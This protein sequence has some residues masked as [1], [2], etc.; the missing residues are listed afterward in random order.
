MLLTPS[1]TL[2][3]PTPDS[4][5]TG[6]FL[7]SEPKRH[8]NPH[9]ARTYHEFNPVTRTYEAFDMNNEENSF[10]DRCPLD[11]RLS[12]WSM[13]RSYMKKEEWEQS[14]KPI[15][16]CHLNNNECSTNFAEGKNKTIKQNSQLLLYLGEISGVFLGSGPEKTEFLLKEYKNRN[17]F[18][19]F[20]V[21]FSE[22]LNCLYVRENN[23]LKEKKFFVQNILEVELLDLEP[24]LITLHVLNEAQNESIENLHFHLLAINENQDFVIFI[25]EKIKTLGKS[26]LIQNKSGKIRTPQQEMREFN[27]KANSTQKEKFSGSEG[28]VP[29]SPPS[30]GVERE[31]EQK[32]VEFTRFSTKIEKDDEKITEE[33]II[34]KLSTPKKN[35][36]E[37]TIYNIFD[38]LNSSPEN[39]KNLVR[40]DSI[41][42]E[43]YEFESPKK[44]EKIIEKAKNNEITNFPKNQKTIETP[45]IH[46]KKSQREKTMSPRKTHSPLPKKE[47]KKKTRKNLNWRRKTR[48]EFIK[49]I[50]ILIKGHNFHKYGLGMTMFQPQKRSLVFSSN[51]E[52]FTFTRTGICPIQKKIYSIHD[53]IRLQAGRKTENFGRFKRSNENRSFSILMKN[54]TIDLEA[55]NEAEMREFCQAFD[56]FLKIC[57][58]CAC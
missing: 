35:D 13:L 31:Q 22:N 43:I 42:E 3:L 58:E 24:Q 9:P 50:R 1:R 12:S 11:L 7:S 30:K 32:L 37:L 38:D 57:K 34:E 53:V 40:M 27:I 33:K 10:N 51:M 54:R 56:N 55:K 41:K 29:S 28:A 16:Y 52:S 17:N 15:C 45:K 48:E 20:Q 26:I 44:P 25:A 47:K 36:K 8:R 6:E 4:P 49:S 14:F 39:S 2:P 21:A 46:K 18:K 5:L 19:K 23:T